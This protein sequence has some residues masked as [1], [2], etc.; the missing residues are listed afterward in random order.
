MAIEQKAL[1]ATDNGMVNG[2]SPIDIEPVQIDGEAGGYVV[3][4]KQ[5]SA[6]VHVADN[7]EPRFQNCSAVAIERP[8]LKGEFFR[9]NGKVQLNIS[10][11]LP[12][13]AT[14]NQ[15]AS[16]ADQIASIATFSEP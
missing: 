8:N 16:I 5:Q 4:R 15:V 7:N 12:D 1:E 13:S 11:S 9:K 6:V 14:E 10:L 3:D 2:T